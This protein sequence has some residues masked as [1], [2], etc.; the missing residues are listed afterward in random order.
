[1]RSSSLAD[2]WGPLKDSRLFSADDVTIQP[3]L[4]LP[5]EVPG[6]DL[7][8][9]PLLHRRRRRFYFD[10]DSVTHAGQMPVELEKAGNSELH[11]ICRCDAVVSDSEELLLLSNSRLVFFICFWCIRISVLE[12]RSDDV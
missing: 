4:V 7:D 10:C 9:V 6:E 12:R 8:L 11:H 5:M 3:V 2:T 1:M